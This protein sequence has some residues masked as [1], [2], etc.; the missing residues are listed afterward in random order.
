M[1]SSVL[2]DP[3]PFQSL[4]SEIRRGQLER[5]QPLNIQKSQLSDLQKFVKQTRRSI[6]DPVLAH[7]ASDP[8]YII[9][10]DEDEPIDP[11]EIRKE[12]EREKIRELKKRKI[13]CALT[14]PVNGGSRRAQRSN[15]VF[16][17]R[18]QDE[19]ADVDV[20]LDDSPRS[21]LEMEPICVSAPSPNPYPIPTLDLPSAPGQPSRNNGHS[22]KASEPAS[23]RKPRQEAKYKPP[24]K[25]IDSSKPKR[26]RGPK[27]DTYKLA[28]SVEEQHLLEQ[29]MEEIP[30][31]VKN[32][33]APSH[34]IHLANS[35]Q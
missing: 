12:L 9:S 7:L 28:W 17:R 11:E 26:G 20:T 25:D 15:G 3:S 14:I 27:S 8:Q 33:Q 22:R 32:R 35:C 18:D 30:D 34:L 10:S 29:L 13:T 24:I 4:A 2:P 6:V 31:G 5:S 19:S 16:I 21:P 1:T 23:L